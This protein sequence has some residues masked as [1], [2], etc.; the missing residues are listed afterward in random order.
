MSY[1]PKISYPIGGKNVQGG[2]PTAILNTLQFNAVTNQWEFVAAPGASLSYLEFLRTEQLAGNVITATGTT[3]AVVPATVLSIIP[4]AGK[5]FF[6]A[7][8]NHAHGNNSGSILAIRTE[9]Q[10][11]TRC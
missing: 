2:L 1:D 5:T 4:A 7:F 3:T 11:G 6:V 8:S 10:P 9:L